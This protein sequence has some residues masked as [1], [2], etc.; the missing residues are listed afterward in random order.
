MPINKPLLGKEEEAAVL[1]VLDSGLLTNP[2]P[3]GGPNVRA[4]EAELATYVH[5]KHSIAV[6]SGTAA[7]QLALMAAGIKPGD[8]V[9][10]PSF[11]FI[12]TASAVMLTGAKPVFV[13]IDRNS[14]NMDPSVLRYAITGKTKAVIPVDLYGL[15][16]NLEEISEEARSRG[17]MLIEDACQAQGSSI[18]GKM[19]GTLGDMGCFSFYPGK[20]MTTGE[21]GALITDDDALADRLR[22]MRTHGQVKGYDSAMLGGNFRMPE[23]EAAMGRVQLRK[24]PG[25]LKKR[26]DNAE[27]LTELLRGTAVVPPLVPEGMRHNWYLYTIRCGNSSDRDRLKTEMNKEGIGATVYYPTPVHRTPYYEGLGFGNIR[28]TETERAASCVLSLPVNPMV[29]DGDLER[30]AS[31]VKRCL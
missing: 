31:I 13:D 17:I 19:A 29:Q 2:S 25:F 22:K 11:T 27:R 12:A 4:F 14:F 28:L 15:P 24:L 16:A 9:I 3:E 1:G 26:T 23:I 20:V 10:V 7:L 8:E 18:K 6:N 30:I 21:G 5:A